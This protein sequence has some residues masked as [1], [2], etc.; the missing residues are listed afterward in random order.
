MKKIVFAT[1][2][3]NKIKEIEQLIGDRFSFFGLKDIQCTEEIPE[4]QDTIKG[5]A[6]QK[7][8][9]IHHH[10]N[11]DCFA[12]DTGLIVPALNG[13]P[14][15]YTARYGGPEKNPEKNMDKLMMD[16]SDG[17]DRSAYFLTVIALILEGKL[18]IFEGR[19][20][21]RIAKK[22]SGEKGFGYDPIFIPEGY[23]ITF[24]QMTMVEKNKISHRSKATKLLKEFLES[25]L[26]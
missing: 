3:T 6:I 2:N 7:A 25:M 22:K 18:H 26:S 13:A 23:D 21:G 16:L 11:Y 9:Y 20:H 8:E 15:V 4:T 12:E 19:A 5:N 1:S 17:K 24:A 10:Y 14:G